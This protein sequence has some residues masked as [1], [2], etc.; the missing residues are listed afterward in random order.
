MSERASV[1]VCACTSTASWHCEWIFPQYFASQLQYAP[2]ASKF[3]HSSTQLQKITHSL[4][5]F[6]DPL[7]VGYPASEIN[8]A[9][10][11]EKQQTQVQ[12]KYLTVWTN[13]GLSSPDP[14]LL[15]TVGQSHYLFMR[16][17]YTSYT[18]VF[19]SNSFY[20]AILKNHQKIKTM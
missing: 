18:E 6:K 10:E 12:C 20:V 11:K 7:Q 19:V 15:C 17:N 14:I 1:S 5:C 13:S 4:F 3:D 8:K 16:I 2:L 9:Q